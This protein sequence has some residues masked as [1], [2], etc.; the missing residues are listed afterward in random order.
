MLQSYLLNCRCPFT[1]ARLDDLHELL[2]PAR[3]PAA[4]CRRGHQGT[5]QPAL[6][7]VALVEGWTRWVGAVVKGTSCLGFWTAISMS[8]RSIC[9]VS[10]LVLREEHRFNILKKGSQR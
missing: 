7:P 4:L 8:V 2:P 6:L 9:L 5:V 10:L 3:F 1:S